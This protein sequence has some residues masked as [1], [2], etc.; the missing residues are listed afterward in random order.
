MSKIDDDV[1]IISLACF[2]PGSDGLLSIVTLGIECGF[3]DNNVN[4]E[5]VICSSGKYNK[6]RGVKF[7]FRAEEEERWIRFF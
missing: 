1:P 7:S 5:T 4:G 2:A 3:G 6:P